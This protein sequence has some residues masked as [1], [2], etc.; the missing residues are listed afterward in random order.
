[1]CIASRIGRCPSPAGAALSQ[2]RGLHSWTY[3]AG[4]A[5]VFDFF[6]FFWSDY[7]SIREYIPTISVAACSRTS[8]QASCM[9]STDKT[10]IQPVR[11]G[12]R[13]QI[14]LE[15]NARKISW[16]NFSRNPGTS[17]YIFSFDFQEK[18]H[19]KVTKISIT[20]LFICKKMYV[21]CFLHI[22]KYKIFEYV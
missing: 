2:I 11:I 21:D 5:S 20:F 13:E 15:H 18:V 3:P 16:R 22:W 9:S 19:L 17:T 8:I 14:A 1:M 6:L 12:N 7:R 4:R 10:R